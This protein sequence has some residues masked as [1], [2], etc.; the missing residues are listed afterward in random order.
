MIVLDAS[1]ILC[2]LFEEPGMDRVLERGPGAFVSAVNLSEALTKAI[3]KGVP[4]E[5]R[6][7]GIAALALHVIEF[8][9][10]AAVEAAELRPVT[11]A[12]GLSLGDRACLALARRLRA[13]VLT[14]DRIWSKL[15]IGVTIEQLR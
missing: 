5:M 6:R 3:D 1:A 4:P 2:V 8:D 9:M 15:D 12:F 7:I 13:P 11:K 10:D 14:T